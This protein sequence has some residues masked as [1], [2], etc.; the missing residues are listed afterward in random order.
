[1]TR[2]FG[3]WIFGKDMN[4]V[5]LGTLKKIGVTDV[6][7]NYYAI[8]TFG[9]AKVISWIEK[10]KQNNINVHI[11]MQCFY[12]GDWINPATTNLDSKLKEA[13]KYATKKE[14]LLLR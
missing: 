5:N 13:K 12:N 14:D 11:W 10:A 1:M 4:K 6:F 3:Y 2:H 9:E 8:N 7:L